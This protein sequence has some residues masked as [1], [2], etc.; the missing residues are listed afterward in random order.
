MPLRARIRS[1]AA[2]FWRWFSYW[3]KRYLWL[4]LA[5]LLI[6]FAP[7]LYG[8]RRPV[9]RQLVIYAITAIDTARFPP[10]FIEAKLLRA[11]EA[12]SLQ[13]ALLV[14][15]DANHDGRL[16]PAEG[17]RLRAATGLAPKELRATS[18]VV[19][20]DRLL[21]ADKKAGLAPRF[22]TSRAMRRWAFDTARAN[23]ARAFAPYHQEVEK[24]LRM[25]YPRPRDYLRWETWRRGINWFRSGLGSHV[26]QL[27]PG[28]FFGLSFPAGMADQYPAGTLQQWPL[29]RG[30]VGWAALALIVVV[31]VRRFFRAEE[32]KRR[33][34]EHPDL[35]EAP[36]PVCGQPTHDLGALRENRLHRAAALGAVVALMVGAVS[37]VTI[38]VFDVP[39]R[40]VTMGRFTWLASGLAVGI[41][42][43]LL[44]P[45]EVHACHRRPRLHL[46]GLAAA[47]LAVAAPLS[48]V[49]AYWVRVFG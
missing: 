25:A 16:Q 6:I 33:L 18:L 2:L 28:V 30:F 23:E 40:G 17:K 14:H 42:R 8:V 12:R 27:A 13:T 37:A 4:R 36:C 20:Y 31:C 41:A 47:A 38:G 49:V 46:I 39:D 43:Y 32:F 21:A 35:A 7:T 24:E 15:F 29:W 45:W 9:I 1:N 10:E 5:I 19:D 44:W 34:E 11:R 22:D 26:D 48:A 3:R